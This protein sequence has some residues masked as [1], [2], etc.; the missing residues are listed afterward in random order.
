[1]GRTGR[2]VGWLHRIGAF[3]A[4]GTTPAALMLGGGL[5]EHVPSS[6]L[7][8]SILLGTL[9]VLTL[10][11]LHGVSGQR[12]GM[13]F[14][15]IATEV[16]GLRA[17][18]LAALLMS[19]L[20]I[21]WYA[22]AIGVGGTALSQLLG[23][24]DFLGILIY[25]TGIASLSRMGLGRW[26][27][28]AVSSIVATTAF[29]LWSVWMLGPPP[30]VVD[31][32]SVGAFGGVLAGSAMVLGFAAAFALRSPDFTSDLKS[33][34]HVIKASLFGLSIPLAIFS[35][36][37]ALLYLGFGT[38]DLPLL[39]KSS[40]LP[41]LANLFLVVGFAASSLANL[42]SA[43]LSSAHLTGLKPQTCFVGVLLVGTAVAA[44]GFYQV[45]V[46]WLVFLG[47]LVPP[48]ILTLVLD[49]RTVEGHHVYRSLLAWGLGTLAGFLGWWLHSDF[50]LLMGLLVPPL[51]LLPRKRS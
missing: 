43:N 30:E 29:L 14:Y 32:P 37:G 18:R 4:I 11:V 19:V 17:S 49:R 28:V 46:L 36:V 25:S 3:A 23:A 26:N 6:S 38:W 34:G 45:M 15:Q 31:S 10:T 48:L 44:M 51:I 5:A 39:L 13:V 21:G 16:L 2:R 7:L 41:V 40:G 24:P 50:Y 8:P 20:M 27:W 22:F 35:F 12:R 42:F 9:L 1:M 47:V 33:G